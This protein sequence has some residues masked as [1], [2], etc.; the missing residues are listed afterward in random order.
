M[1]HTIIEFADLNLENIFEEIVYPKTPEII[2]S[3]KGVD[4]SIV[5]FLRINQKHC[6]NY[7]KVLKN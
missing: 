7:H 6:P 3:S 5:F 2:K 4:Q 1:D